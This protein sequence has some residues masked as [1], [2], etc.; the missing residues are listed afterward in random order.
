MSEKLKFVLFFIAFAAIS[1]L[2]APVLSY[3]FLILGCVLCLFL[4][5]VDFF[6]SVFTWGKSDISLAQSTMQM[7]NVMEPLTA[8]IIF[9]IIGG[10]VLL[11][12]YS[13]SLFDDGHN[14]QS[15]GFKIKSSINGRNYSLGKTNG[16]STNEDTLYMYI[17][18]ANFK[19]MK[20]EIGGERFNHY[21]IEKWLLKHGYSKR[22]ITRILEI[23]DK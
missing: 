7:I 5:I 14:N 18:K 8:W 13:D 10:I 23:L 20:H 1:F 11:F 16:K 21:N 2:F 9:V 12:C 17:S 3:V 4:F 15:L 22:A 6:I 19:S